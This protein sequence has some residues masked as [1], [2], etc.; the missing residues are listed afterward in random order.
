M[1]LVCPCAVAVMVDAVVGVCVL[2]CFLCDFPRC[3][4]VWLLYW[5]VCFVCVGLFC[6]VL[7]SLVVLVCLRVF[8]VFVCSCLL[9]VLMS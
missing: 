8:C 3:R 4:V 1:S 5:F 9:C 7:L 6:V 2:R